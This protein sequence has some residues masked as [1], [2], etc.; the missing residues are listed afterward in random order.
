MSIPTISRKVNCK[1]NLGLQILQKRDDGFHEIRT[2]F[3]PTNFFA[4][5][6][7]VEASASEFEFVCHSIQ[8]IGLA[9]DNLCVR[10]FRLLQRDF[11]IA[12]VRLT[13]DKHIPIG[14]GLGGGSA[15]AAFT[16]TMLAEAFQ[17]PISIAQLLN[18]AA[19][20]GS[21]VP[22]FVENRPMYATGRGEILQPIDLDLSQYE[23]RIVKPNF[24]VSTR[25][26]YAGVIPHTPNVDLLTIIQRPVCE[27]KNAMHN[28]FENT[29]FQNYPIL[30]ELK[31]NF[32][33]QG[34]S[35]AAMSGSGTA[36]FGLF[37]LS[38]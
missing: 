37:P 30:S 34:A 8:N 31:T 5:Q 17:L 6:L 20:L 33:S 12:G 2:I 16:L 7:T 13:L 9:D 21:D 23:I 27:W 14:A 18:Y 19:Q 36:V 4:D 32:Y 10:A 38:S 26:A 15:D 24:A 1:I 3:Y 35:Y 22:F 11:G 29:I 28:D 25:E